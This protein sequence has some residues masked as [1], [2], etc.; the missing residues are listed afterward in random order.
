MG[1]GSVQRS[2]PV[3]MKALKELMVLRFVQ[4][5]PAHGYALSDAL[6]GSFGWLVGLTRP[7]VYT[8]LQRMEKMGWLTFEAD[9]EGRYPERQVY[10]LTAEGRAA[11]VDLLQETMQAGGL[12]TQPLAALLLHLDELDADDRVESL[13]A[14]RESRIEMQERLATFPHHGGAAN[15]ALALMRDQL[16]VELRAISA[17]LDDRGAGTE[18]GPR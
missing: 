4:D 3:N 11:Y 12:C 13:L 7:T 1:S 16:D 6:E 8:V 5:H 2:P 18:S 14:L 17:L 9:R 15:V 10:S